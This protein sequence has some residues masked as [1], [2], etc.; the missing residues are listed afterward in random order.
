MIDHLRGP[1]FFTTVAATG[2]LGSQFIGL[3]RDLL[4]RARGFWR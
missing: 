1:G 2:I 4:R 3:L